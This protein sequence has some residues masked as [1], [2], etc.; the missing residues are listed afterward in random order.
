MLSARR[1][2]AITVPRQF[3]SAS[4]PQW[5]A[6][7]DKGHPLARGLSFF[8]T[9]SDSTVDLTGNWQTLTAGG[10]P[11]RTNSPYGAALTVNG[12]TDGVGIPISANGATGS[13]IGSAWSSVGGSICV[14]FSAS[15]FGG[16]I[17]YEDGFGSNNFSIAFPANGASVMQVLS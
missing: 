1:R 14:L 10:T 17:M 3:N 2:D 7:I 11:T 15:A 5:A 13:I 12:S 6:Q 4:A 9:F 8:S 16:Q